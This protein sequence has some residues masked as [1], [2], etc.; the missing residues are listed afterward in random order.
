MWISSR[1]EGLI[2]Q[3]SCLMGSATYQIHPQARRNWL[4]E[5]V[6]LFKVVASTFGRGIVLAKVDKS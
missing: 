6:A 5:H 1:K 3:L 4:D 2:R